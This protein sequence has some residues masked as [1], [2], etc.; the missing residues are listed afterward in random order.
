MMHQL[1]VLAAEAKEIYVH[2][3]FKEWYITFIVEQDG[4]KLEVKEHGDDLNEVW[5]KAVS[6]FRRITGA[7]PELL[8]P[9]LTAPDPIPETPYREITRDQLDDDIPF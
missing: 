6:K 5:D 1:I 4:M 7:A 8:P 2:R 9:R 3:L